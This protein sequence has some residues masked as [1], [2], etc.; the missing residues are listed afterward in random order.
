MKDVCI[1]AEIIISTIMTRLTILR[2]LQSYVAMLRLIGLSQLTALTGLSHI[3]WFP[4]RVKIVA[5][6]VV[7]IINVLLR[8]KSLWNTG[9]FD[10]IIVI[11][12]LVESLLVSLFETVMM[13]VVIIIVV[14]VVV[15]IIIVLSR[16]ILVIGII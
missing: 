3:V 11:L 7:A 4:P 2:R 5:T 8:I 6:V 13:T 16:M 1:D 15:I 10:M 14:V 12:R 9:I